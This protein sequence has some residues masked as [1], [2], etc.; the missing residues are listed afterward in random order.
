MRDWVLAKL[1]CDRVSGQQ[2][3]EEGAA[4]FLV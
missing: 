1:Q 2:A 4:D 3:M